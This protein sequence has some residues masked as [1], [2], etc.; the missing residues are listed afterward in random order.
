MTTQN[1]LKQSDLE[2]SLDPNGDTAK[3]EYVQ[4]TTTATLMTQSL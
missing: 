2:K 3:E 4:V 1:Y